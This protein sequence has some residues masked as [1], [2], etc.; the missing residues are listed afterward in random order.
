MNPTLADLVRQIPL[1]GDVQTMSRKALPLMVNLVGA[2]NGSL[3]LLSGGRVVQKILANRETFTDVS[4]HKIQTVLS[5]GLAGW[6]L[7]H[8]QGGLASDTTL[9]ER[10]VSMG[11]TSIGSAMVVPMF[12]RNQVTGL[13]SFHHAERSHF[14]ESHLAMAAELGQLTGPLFDIAMMSESS[15][16]SLRSVCL[17]ASHPSA[18]I[19]WQ[20][21]VRAVNKTMESLDIVWPD[22]TFQQSLL[23]RELA[24]AHI[25]DCEW[26]GAR[27][28]ATLPFRAT[29]VHFYGIGV[30]I[31]LAPKS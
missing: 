12:S 23:P 14:R 3:M 18:L 10:W 4:D 15:I 17:A 22:G 1:F 28:L 6:A 19:D 13:L 21:K 25:T 7:N 30:W 24:A 26:N 16:A 5:S 8:R 2:D 29:A 27:D 20:G 9:D 11:D 31:Q